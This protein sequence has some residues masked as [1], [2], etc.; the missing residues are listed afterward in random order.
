MP[1]ISY[2]CPTALA[3]EQERLA[4]VVWEGCGVR[5]NPA[6]SEQMAFFR[7]DTLLHY[8]RSRERVNWRKKATNFSSSRLTK[9]EVRLHATTQTST[10]MA[11]A[12][13]TWAG[14]ITVHI[15]DHSSTQAAFVAA[16]KWLPRVRSN[17]VTS[18]RPTVP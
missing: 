12:C 4:R 10:P 8:E 2:G 6:I 13:C 18:P 11:C 17:V 3:M 5:G 7:V 1:I 14:I 16:S 9:Q 15:N